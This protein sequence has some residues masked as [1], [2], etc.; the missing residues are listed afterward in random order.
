MSWLRPVFLFVVASPIGQLG[1]LT[2]A[3]CTAD[4]DCVEDH[5][6]TRTGECVPAGTAIRV[7][8]RWT[9][10]GQAPSP[11]RPEPCEPIGELEVVFH[12]GSLQPQN[13][14]PVPCNFGRTVY[15]KM[16]SRFDS[17]E[18][19]AYDPA[20]RFLDAAEE[21]LARSGETDIE[22]DLTP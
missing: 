4:T 12:D 21:M 11:M 22:V 5:E 9:V 17:V 19:I 16:P 20:D 14:R 1:C 15:D 8:V 7:V 10:N 18:V 6:C 13:Y 3:L 2:G